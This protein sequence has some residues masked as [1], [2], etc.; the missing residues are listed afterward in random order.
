LTAKQKAKLTS[1]VKIQQLEIAHKN[2]K[3]DDDLRLEQ[4]GKKRLI[5]HFR[6]KSY[7]DYLKAEEKKKNG[8][9]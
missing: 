1:V 8:L 5:D 3:E 2:K 7:D 4:I 9:S 6:K